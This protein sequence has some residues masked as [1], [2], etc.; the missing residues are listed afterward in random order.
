MT[1][2]ILVITPN[3]VV[4]V[5]DRLV[6]VSDGSVD[7][8]YKHFTL[9]T[10]DARVIFSIVGFAGIK[11]QETTIDWLLHE[12][13][14]TCRNGYHGIEQHLQDVRKHAQGYINRFRARG[15]PWENLQLGI[16]ASGWVRSEQFNV[17]IDNGLERWWTWASKARPSFKTRIRNYVEYGLPA[18]C[19]IGY[20]GHER[21]AL[22]QRRL[23][24]LM[25]FYARK[26]EIKKVVRIAVEIIRS[27]AKQGGRVGVDCDAIRISRGDPGIQI[28]TYRGNKIYDDDFPDFVVSTSQKCFVSR[29]LK[30]IEWENVN[31]RRVKWVKRSAGK[32]HS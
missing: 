24:Q 3:H 7:E 14:T 11:G 6:T 21:N 20:F 26:E 22:K 17:V 12:I 19:A 25:T 2:H 4:S 30:D 1:L 13:L 18:G 29:G 32:N 15:I 5:S 27:V 10:D 31:G 28:F 9:V 23:R 8:M 16:M